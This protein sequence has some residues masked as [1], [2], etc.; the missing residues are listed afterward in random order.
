MTR[1]ETE[2][3]G[4][5]VRGRALRIGGL[6]VVVV[7]AVVAARARAAGM[8]PPVEAPTRS[9]AE[10]VMRIVAVTIMVAGIILLLWGKRPQLVKGAPGQIKKRRTAGRSNKRVVIACLIGLLFAVAVQLLGNAA[11]E[12]RKDQAPPPPP[13]GQQVQTNPNA[14]EKG[15]PGAGEESGIGDE[16]LLAVGAITLG[17]LIYL[18]VR[19]NNV[20]LEDD[21][22]EDEEEAVARAM[23]AGQA[24]VA[25]RTITDPRE[26]IVACFAAMESALASRGGAVTPQAADT[27]W[28][29]LRRGIDEASLP[30][31]AASTLLR[32][33]REARYST[34][35]M[36][37]EDRADADTALGELLRGLGTPA[38]GIS[39]EPR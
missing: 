9:V 1:P 25:D 27:P 23:R 21:E 3:D 33:F 31:G 15:Q 34:H 16:I 10:I 8:T 35:P 7:L 22:E 12:K 19:R 4:E 18:L 5:E 14:R 38:A 11:N 39:G 36:V 2:T 28:E 26:A 30:A 13:P 6:A 24:A 37:E 17:A 32:L 20:V 29:V